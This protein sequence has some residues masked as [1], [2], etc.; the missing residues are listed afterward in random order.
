MKYSLG[1]H[2]SAKKNEADKVASAF[3]SFWDEKYPALMKLISEVAWVAAY[4]DKPLTYK[5]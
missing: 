4:P 2:G 3:Y 1:R 5:T